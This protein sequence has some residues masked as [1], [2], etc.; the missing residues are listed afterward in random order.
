MSWTKQELVEQA[1]NEIAKN[2]GTFNIDADALQSALRSMDSMM[3]T[4]DGKG[5]RVGYLLPSSPGDSNL[6]DD[7]GLPDWAVE[8]VYLSL[9]LRIAPSIGKTVAVETRI[10]AKEAYNVLLL[11]PAF[12]PQQQLPNTL[13]RGAGNKPWRGTGNQ[14]MPTPTE[15]LEAFEGGDQITE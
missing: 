11:R 5:V 12:P 14:F 9:A 2:V 8:A 1:F 7:A 13:P 4:W 6:D 15:P 10:N 3:A